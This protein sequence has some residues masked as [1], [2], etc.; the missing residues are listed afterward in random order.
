MATKVET[1]TAV[2]KYEPSSPHRSSSPLPPML[3]SRHSE[4]PEMRNLY[5]RLTSYMDA[6]SCLENENCRLNDLVQAL[7]EASEREIA[8]IKQVYE[9]QLS[10]QRQLVDKAILEKA[11][12]EIDY[13][14]MLEE[15]EELKQ[16]YDNKN[17]EALISEETARLYSSSVA[18]H[19]KTI[20]DAE[21]VKLESIK[22]RKQLEESWNNMAKE[23]VARVKLENTIRSLQE[24]IKLKDQMYNAI[25][26]ENLAHRQVVS[27]E[28]DSSIDEQY[29][30]KFQ[31][32]LLELRD[33]YEDQMRSKQ[34]EIETLFEARI[35]NNWTNTQRENKNL[36]STIKYLYSRIDLSNT[37]NGK[38]EEN[39][40]S[41]INCIRDLQLQLDGEKARTTES[42]AEVNRLRGELAL[43]LQKY[44]D[45][46]DIKASLDLDFAACGKLLC[47]PTNS[48]S[49]KR[50]SNSTVRGSPAAKRNRN[51]A[52]EIVY[53][54]A[55]MTSSTGDIEMIELDPATKCVK[56]HNNSENE[57]A[58]GGWQLI[59]KAG[60]NET[61]YKFDSS[62]KVGGGADLIIWS[63][64]SGVSATPGNIIMDSQNWC[65]AQEMKSTLVNGKKY[66]KKNIKKNL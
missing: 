21:N 55:T 58:L 11:K 28:H 50:L 14:R 26:N 18:E 66:F 59:M 27:F 13:Q 25:Q 45:L 40:L 23:T 52:F 49:F 30:S 6:V 1:I 53:S 65:V 31:E 56:L 61:L 2:Q 48:G 10:E 41:L 54:Y 44:Q 9:D 12:L 24:E 8:D 33:Q 37:R 51:E 47:Q 17:K 7:T 34:E 38:L 19:K 62:A 5:D 63:A 20:V 16:K 46:L 36:K 43:Q 39:N 32:S 42:E 4:N 29:K 64:D 3:Q 35:K 60:G 57:V 15:K 22:L